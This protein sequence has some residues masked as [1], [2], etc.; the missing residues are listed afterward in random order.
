MRT[1]VFLH[2]CTHTHVQVRDRVC[3][4]LQSLPNVNVCMRCVCMG[5]YQGICACLCLR[6]C[7]N[8][9]VRACMYACACSCVCAAARK[10][11]CLSYICAFLCTCAHVGRVC[12]RMHLRINVCVAL[13]WCKLS[14][15]VCLFMLHMCMRTR[16]ILQS[17][18][19]FLCLAHACRQMVTVVC[20]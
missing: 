5:A 1:H 14:H 17:V 3:A 11:R 12:A 20:I 6:M 7:V 2:A 8:V 9:Y 4:F 16:K 15:K 13:H 10:C 18:S 19:V